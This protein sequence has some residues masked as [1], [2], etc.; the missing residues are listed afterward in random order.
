MSETKNKRTGI[1]NDIYMSTKNMFTALFRDDTEEL[2]KEALKNRNNNNNSKKKQLTIIYDCRKH[3]STRCYFCS[4]IPDF[5]CSI[6][7]TYAGNN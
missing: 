3:F 1:L 5:G 6:F 7:H 2:A 4:S